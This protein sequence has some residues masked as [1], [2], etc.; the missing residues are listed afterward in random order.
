[1]KR[2]APKISGVAPE[3]SGILSMFYCLSHPFQSF[4]SLFEFSRIIL[5]VA[6]RISG[7]T[8]SFKDYNCTILLKSFPEFL[9]FIAIFKNNREL[10]EYPGLHLGLLELYSRI[11]ELQRCLRLRPELPAL[12]LWFPELQPFSGLA[13]ELQCINVFQTFSRVFGVNQNF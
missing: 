8:P 3:V 10:P 4:W 5:G 7:F 1:M 9:K 13:P 6:P 11:P 2:S 12:H